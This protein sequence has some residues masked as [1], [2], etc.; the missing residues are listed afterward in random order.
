M[1]RTEG[2]VQLDNERVRITEWR[3]AP[4]AATG[5]H[6][7]AYNYVVLPLASGRLR[8]VPPD[9]SES[10][11]EPQHGQSYFRR[12]GIE[13]DVV[14]ANNDNLAFVEIELK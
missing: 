5:R 9:G 3:F 4:G 13:H 1:T 10:F 6:R 2:I 14:N 12:V 11:A 7:H 8:I